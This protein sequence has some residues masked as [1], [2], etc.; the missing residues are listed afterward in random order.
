[1]SA[2]FTIAPLDSNGLRILTW[3]ACGCR[4][5]EET[6]ISLW[7]ALAESKAN[8]RKLA[9]SSIRIHAQVQE[10]N[11]ELKRQI[12]EGELVPVDVVGEWLEQD[13]LNGNTAVKANLRKFAAERQK[14]GVTK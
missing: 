12:T 7:D 5:A 2:G 13:D 4:P 6:E 14:E 3:D 11:A 9:E 8:H 1:M 10:E